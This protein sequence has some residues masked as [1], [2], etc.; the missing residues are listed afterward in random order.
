MQEFN[1]NV[2][3]TRYNRFD[4]S[5]RFIEYD[6]CKK[7][8]LKRGLKSIDLKEYLFINK[9]SSEDEEAFNI[10]VD[11]YIK[12]LEDDYSFIIN[13]KGD[14]IISGYRADRLLDIINKVQNTKYNNKDLKKILKF[15][16]DNHPELRLYVLMSRK[17]YSVLLID[18]Y[19]LAIYG[20]YKKNGKLITIPMDKR[21]RRYR[22]NTCC[23]ERIIDLVK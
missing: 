22:K 16:Y 18:L 10:I 3:K 19:H 13:L 1:N 20:D 12:C 8:D 6:I 7:F 17:N 5:K 23:L 2:I 9:A 21:Y 14:E 11:L 4:R 15:R